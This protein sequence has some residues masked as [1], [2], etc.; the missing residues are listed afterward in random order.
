MG[1]TRTVKLTGVPAGPPR[2][3]APEPRPTPSLR[4]VADPARLGEAPPVGAGRRGLPVAPGAGRRRAD[5]GWPGRAVGDLPAGGGPGRAVVGKPNG[6]P[7]P[8]LGRGV[9]A[10][11]PDGARA[12][13]LSR[14]TG[15]ARCRRNG[16]GRV[17]VTAF[18]LSGAKAPWYFLVDIRSPRRVYVPAGA[19]RRTG[20]SG[21][22]STAWASPFRGALSCT[23]GRTAE[24]GD[25]HCSCSSSPQR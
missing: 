17:P 8:P 15:R 13:L 9:R 22:P 23:A 3:P 2:R 14:A 5:P 12:S 21:R 6:G 24:R 11:L 19:A 1:A 16:S 10:H 18:R 7:D 25:W 4:R 20:R